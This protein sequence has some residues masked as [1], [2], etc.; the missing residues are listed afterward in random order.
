LLKRR[1]HSFWRRRYTTFLLLFLLIITVTASPF[2]WRVDRLSR[3][4]S[5]YDVQRVKEELL[6]WKVHGG[7]LNQLAVIRDATLWLDLN[8]GGENL[9]S[10]L[11]MAQD[12]KHQ[13]WLFLLN[14][15]KGQ[16][17]EAQNVLN[18]LDKTSLGQL[19][20]GM[21]SMTKGD[22]EASRRLLAEKELDWKTLPEQ[23]QVLRHLALAQAAVIV[24]DHQVTQTELEGAQRLEPNN[25]ACL[26]MAFDIAIGDARWAQ[27]QE[28][29]GIIKAQTWRP[30]NTLFETKRAVL[31]IHENDLQAL[32][33]CLSTLQELPTGEASINYVKGLQALSKGQLQEGQSLL[34]RALKIGLE[35]GLK[36][37][38]QKSLDQVTMRQN[39]DRA[40]RSMV[41]G[42]EE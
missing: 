26:S 27:A 35:G 6:W 20:Q 7:L 11:A 30:K 3:A 5:D 15:Q 4:E 13:F 18:R 10:E 25:P 16:V 31:A 39:A 29:S 24:G 9:E 1:K 14:L 19:G 38:A 42:K 28:L 36:A 8:V 2:V 23:A 34:E 40:F 32:T 22:V 17:T 12:E 41:D 37:D 21:M 33:E